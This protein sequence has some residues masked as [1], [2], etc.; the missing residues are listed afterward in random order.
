MPG[1]VKK[2]GVIIY[3]SFAAAK[4]DLATLAEKTKQYDQFNIVIRQEGNMDDPDLTPY[5]RIFAGAAWTL[6]NE[7]RIA[8]GW[9]DTPH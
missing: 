6:I 9:Y 3:E 5:G 2:Y 7:R 8:E 1:Q 4:S